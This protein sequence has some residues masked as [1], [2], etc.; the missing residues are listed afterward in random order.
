[1]E[2]AITHYYCIKNSQ[3]RQFMPKRSN[4]NY[5]PQHRKLQKLLLWILPSVKINQ[6]ENDPEYKNSKINELP[7]GKT[8]NMHRRKQERRSASQ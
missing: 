1:M 6:Q 3:L 2:Y 7:H 8:I 5:V 4:F